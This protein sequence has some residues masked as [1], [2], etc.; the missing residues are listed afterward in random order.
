MLEFWAGHGD[1]GTQS[2][3]SNVTMGK[4]GERAHSRV[5][6][7]DDDSSILDT[8]TAILSGE[9]YLVMAAGGGKEALALVRSWHPTLVLLDM[10]MPVM[11]GWAVARALH[12]A[13]SRVPIIV[14]TAA[15]SARRWADE[16]GAAGHLAKPFSLDE[17]IQCVEKF[18]ADERKN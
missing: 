7:V 17:L 5:L 11:D 12:E 18:S 4:G 6:V 14:M 3:D 13:G 10:R 2:G 8:V 9:G 1:G 16:I 15:E